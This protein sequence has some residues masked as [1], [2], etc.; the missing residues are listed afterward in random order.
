MH[1]DLK[2]LIFFAAW[3]V[4]CL[5]AGEIGSFFGWGYYGSDEYRYI[6]SEHN[7]VPLPDADYITP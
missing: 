1:D 6:N 4:I 3:L 2:V 7:T 5:F